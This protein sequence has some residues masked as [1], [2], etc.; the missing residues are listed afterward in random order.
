[1]REDMMITNPEDRVTLEVE[2]LF[3]TNKVQSERQ[4]IDDNQ[5]ER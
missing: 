1:M 4:I 5:D 2:A 3:T